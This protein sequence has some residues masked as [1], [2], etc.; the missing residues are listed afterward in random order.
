MR[1]YSDATLNQDRLRDLKMLKMR[2]FQRKSKGK[3]LLWPIFKVRF[4]FF[5]TLF[6]V[7]DS[8]LEAYL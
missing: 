5:K 6:E 1:R 7:M 4:V 3:L 2:Q 8:I